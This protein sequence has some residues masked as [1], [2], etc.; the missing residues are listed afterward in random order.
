[1]GPPIVHKLQAGVGPPIVH[2]LQAVKK[3]ICG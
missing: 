3:I 2:K 1:V